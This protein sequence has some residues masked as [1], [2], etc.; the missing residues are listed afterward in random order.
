[1]PLYKAEIYEK[2]GRKREISE[3]ASSESELI[4]KLTS[5]GHI[6]TLVKEECSKRS[7]FQ[8]LRAEGQYKRYAQ[9]TDTRHAND[10]YFGTF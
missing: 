6:V 7:L 10:A 1:M 5:R 9:I 2:D 4:R 3:E 8:T